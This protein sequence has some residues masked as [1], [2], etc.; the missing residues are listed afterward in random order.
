MTK[1]K[2]KYRSEIAGVVH[3]GVRGLPFDPGLQIFASRAREGA[4]ILRL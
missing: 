3:E 1:T 2:G 4:G